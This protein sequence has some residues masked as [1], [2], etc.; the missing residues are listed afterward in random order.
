[1]L[2]PTPVRQRMRGFGLALAGVVWVTPDAVIVRWSAKIGGGTFWWIICVKC[3]VLFV[4]IMTFVTWQHG[5]RKIPAGILAGPAHIALVTCMQ[6]LVTIGFPAAFLT[7]T[8]AKALLLISLNPLWAT[9]LGW[10]VLGDRLPR[11]T[12]LALVGAGCSVASIFI[13]PAVLRETAEEAVSSDG[14]GNWRGDLIAV[15]TGMA[16]AGMITANRFGAQRRPKALMAL[17]ASLGSLVASLIALVFAC[18]IASEREARLEPAFWPLMLLDGI[19]VAACT[20]LALTFAPRYISGAE[21]ALVMLLEVVLGPL[22]VFL[23]GFEAP[24]QW[25]LIGGAGIIVVLGVHELA[26][27]REARRLAGLPDYLPEDRV[28]DAKCVIVTGLE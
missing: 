16:L 25:T 4:A 24:T 15:A 17:G 12:V 27:L 6:C 3:A 11:R 14:V 20:V 13:P 19:C 9:M 10:R 7:T 8:A 21:V 18:T 1:M 28:D 26:A 2:P 5:L 22:W 23:A